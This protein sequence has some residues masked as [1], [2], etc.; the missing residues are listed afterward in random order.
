MDDQTGI[1][2]ENG[3]AAQTDNNPATDNGQTAAESSAAESGNAQNDGQSTDNDPEDSPIA[4]WSALDLGLADDAPV[5]SATLAAFGAQAVALGLTPKQARGLVNWQL[6]AISEGRQQLLDNG[7]AQ[8]KKA[9]GGRY[10]ANRRAALSLV[11]QLDR[12]LGNDVFSKALADSGAALC[13]PIVMGL[14]ALAARL[15]EDS[16]G[17]SAPAT[18]QHEETA[19]EGMQEVFRAARG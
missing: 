4:D 9:W 19:L 5:D 12:E 2:P 1:E 6:A 14:A 18:P 13:A 17:K 10:E 15:G 7:M 16:M 11:S 3:A 8:L